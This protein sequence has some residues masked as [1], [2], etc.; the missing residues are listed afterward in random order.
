MCH[1]YVTSCREDVVA[2]DSIQALPVVCELEDPKTAANCA[3][4]ANVV[5]VVVVELV[6]AVLAGLPA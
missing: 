4:D 2:V 1:L 6:V 3:S 5:V